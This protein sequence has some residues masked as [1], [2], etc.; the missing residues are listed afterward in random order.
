[1]QQSVSKG[2]DFW[3]VVMKRAIVIFSSIYCLSFSTT[4][5]CESKLDA[6]VVEAN[7]LVHR[8]ESDFAALKENFT[9]ASRPNSF[10]SNSLKRKQLLLQKLALQLEAMNTIL[11]S[12][13]QKSTSCNLPNSAVQTSVNNRI[14]DVYN[15]TLALRQNLD[16]DHEKLEFLMK[17]LTD[18]NDYSALEDVS[19][20][21]THLQ[22][23]I[24]YLK[25]WY[26]SKRSDGLTAEIIARNPACVGKVDVAPRELFQRAEIPVEDSDSVTAESG[27]RKVRI[28]VDLRQNNISTGLENEAPGI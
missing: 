13:L 15:S 17:E 12:S 3:K 24:Q 16:S 2:R 9:T 8:S 23:K 11:Q 6:F 26:N 10:C 7:Q 20:N 28:D 22:D 19:Q 27:L 1:M 21:L 14:Q 18:T 25:D 5:S 4:G